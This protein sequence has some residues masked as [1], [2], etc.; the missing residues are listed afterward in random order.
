MYA[1]D[2][3]TFIKP[4]RADLLACATVVE[5]FGEASGLRTNR[6]KCS[7]HPIHCTMEQVEL[8]QSILQCLV[9]GW[10]CKYSGLPLGCARLP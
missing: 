9:E 6:T 8:A 5:D 2:V 1:D 10:P 4:E 3:V 7:L